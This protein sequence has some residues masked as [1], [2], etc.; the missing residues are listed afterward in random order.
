MKVNPISVGVGCKKTPI[1]S[2]MLLTI[3]GSCVP[4][5]LRLQTTILVSIGPERLWMTRKSPIPNRVKV[6]ARRVLPIVPHQTRPAVSA[7]IA[8][9]R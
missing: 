1:W 4:G 3:L 8:A 6:A 7:N 9:K 2:E 5:R